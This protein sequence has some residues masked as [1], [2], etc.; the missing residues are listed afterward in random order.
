MTL[1][2][3]TLKQNT[4]TKE[5]ELILIFFSVVSGLLL[6]NII[7]IFADDTTVN[8]MKSAFSD[9]TQNFSDNKPARIFCS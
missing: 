5:K 7:Y 8:M 2:V 9:F 1:K 3:S 6:G 4:I